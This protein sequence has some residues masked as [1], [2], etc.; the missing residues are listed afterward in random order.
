MLVICYAGSVLIVAVLMHLLIHQ[1]GV[2]STLSGEPGFGNS[3]GEAFPYFP[4]FTSTYGDRFRAFKH[5]ALHG[6]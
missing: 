5:G 3:V 6:V 4:D 1:M 2:Y